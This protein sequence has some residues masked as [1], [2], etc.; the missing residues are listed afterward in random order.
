MGP[1]DGSRTQDDCERR[2]Y[3]GAG[4]YPEVHR[5]SRRAKAEKLGSLLAH[6]LPQHRASHVRRSAARVHGRPARVV[7]ADRVAPHPPALAA[8][9]PRHRLPL[10]TVRAAAPIAT[11]HPP[12]LG[13][14]PHTTRPSP[15]CGLSSR[16][17]GQRCLAGALRGT[18]RRAGWHL[19]DVPAAYR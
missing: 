5:P 7:V 18:A 12:F 15:P 9:L 1:P 11:M 14:V 4:A 3:A 10:T 13:L 2:C 17:A 6:T 16:L 19:P 8:Q